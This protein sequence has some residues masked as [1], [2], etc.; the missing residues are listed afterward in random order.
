MRKIKPEP[1]PWLFLILWTEE[2]YDNFGCRLYDL[3]RKLNAEEARIETNEKG[4]LI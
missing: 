4:N 3:Y 1:L 2:V